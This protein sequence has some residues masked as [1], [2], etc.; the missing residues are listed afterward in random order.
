MQRFVL[1]CRG[2][3]NNALAAAVCHW[4]LSCKTRPGQT[5]LGYPTRH[6]APVP[7]AD[8]TKSRRLMQ[9]VAPTD[10]ACAL[11][12]SLHRYQVFLTAD[13]S[14]HRIR[15][16]NAWLSSKTVRSKRGSNAPFD[17]FRPVSPWCEAK[18]PVDSPQSNKTLYTRPTG[19]RD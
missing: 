5:A 6:S 17:D 18:E 7:S 2:S 12:G 19:A 1:V 11:R 8:T 13:F 16:Q 14:C 15:R 9:S 3:D 4:T 10:R